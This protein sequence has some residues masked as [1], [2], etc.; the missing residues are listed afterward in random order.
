MSTTG[1]RGAGLGT[2]VRDLVRDVPEVEAAS[3]VSYDGLALAE[4]LPAGMDPDRVA[5]MSAAL[6]SLGERAS[7]GLGRGRLQQ[8]LVEGDEGLVVLVGCGDEAVLVVASPRG[9]KTGLVLYE[10]RRAAARVQSLLLRDDEPVGRQ[11]LADAAS[12]A[13]AAYQPRRAAPPAGV[14]SQGATAS[15]PA[16]GAVV[17]RAASY[18]PS[19]G[20][21]APSA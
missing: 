4:A 8:V 18:A 20:S 10:A 2:T 6:L 12:E 14:P 5:A 19:A 15:G 17:P 16:P 7:E 3:V 21:A 13:A 11:A 9:A 1:S